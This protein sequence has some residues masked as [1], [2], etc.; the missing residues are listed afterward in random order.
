MAAT[1]DGENWRIAGILHYFSLI[2]LTTVGYGDVSPVAPIARNVAAV[3][4]V[5]AQLFIAAVI[6]R[7]VAMHTTPERPGSGEPG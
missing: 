1:F 2:T 7:L 3:E 4:A 5:I 6:A